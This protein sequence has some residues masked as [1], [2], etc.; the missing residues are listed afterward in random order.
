MNANPTEQ[1]KK[2]T[3]SPEALIKRFPDGVCLF[4]SP[5]WRCDP[6]MKI[7]Q[8]DGVEGNGNP[9][10]LYAAANKNGNP[11]YAK[12]Q[13][14]KILDSPYLFLSDQRSRIIQHGEVICRFGSPQAA[15][16][17]F[18]PPGFKLFVTEYL[19]KTRQVA[20]T[21]KNHLDQQLDIAMSGELDHLEMAICPDWQIWKTPCPADNIKPTLFRDVNGD[22][23]PITGPEFMSRLLISKFL[24]IGYGFRKQDHNFIIVNINDAANFF[25]TVTDFARFSGIPQ[26]I[27]NTKDQGPLRR[28]DLITGEEI[29][30]SNSITD[31]L[32]NRFA[33]DLKKSRSAALKDPREALI[34]AFCTSTFRQ[35]GMF[36]KMSID[37]NAQNFDFIY[38][39][40][41]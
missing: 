37:R 39:M 31:H 15:L 5:K 19:L 35:S 11:G 27:I 38:N 6:Q 7:I 14:D 23:T 21:I 9:V 34:S 2:R 4:L 28:I 40:D 36:S 32:D 33:N 20:K 13:L 30:L 16:D 1:P 18:L 24:R 12:S 26:I 17:S 3:E 41:K 8:I 25:Q 10:T 22:R 29:S